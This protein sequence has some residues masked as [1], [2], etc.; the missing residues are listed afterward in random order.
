MLGF[1][2]RYYWGRKESQGARGIVAV[3]AWMCSEDKHLK[4]YVHLYSSLGWDSLVCHSGCLNMFAPVQATSLAFDFLNELVKELKTRPCPLVFASF[5]GGPKACMYKVLQIIDGNCEGHHYRDDFQLV[6]NCISGFIFD[7]SP[8]DFISTLAF[9]FFLHPSV[10]KRP[11]PPK[12]LSWIANG[13]RAGIDAVSLSSSESQ[14]ADYW[15]TLYASASMGGPYLFLCSEIDDL[16]SYQVIRNFADRLQELGANVEVVAWES[17]PHVGHYRIH[18]KEYRTAVAELLGKAFLVYSQRS[19]KLE[20]KGDSMTLEDTGSLGRVSRPIS[21]VR[22]AAEG[23]GQSFHQ[24]MAPEGSHHSSLP[25]SIECYE[26][27]AVGSMGDEEDEAGCIS[28]LSLPNMA[29]VSSKAV[30]KILCDA[31]AP[32]NVE[33]WDITDV[34]PPGAPES[35]PFTSAP[36]RAASRSKL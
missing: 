5:S 36:S 29:T 30:G 18:P 15:Q 8:V 22:K 13:I 25:G 3:F 12:L 1:G 6:K 19:H 28:L 27:M 11:H 4:N 17:S 7:S 35:L 21:N 33:S 34:R 16:A 23:S 9:K 2:G 24:K 10:I 26:G 14:R 20:L 32:K 31:S